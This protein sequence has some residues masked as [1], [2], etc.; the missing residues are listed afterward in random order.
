MGV[1][2][3]HGPGVK[4]GPGG[5]GE[6]AQSRHERRAVPFI[7]HDMSAVQPPKKYVVEEAGRGIQTKRGKVS[8]RGRRSMVGL[9]LLPG[10]GNPIENNPLSQLRSKTV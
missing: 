2:R 3:R 6:V 5:R 4:R 1:V 7:G 10:G 8:S 9:S